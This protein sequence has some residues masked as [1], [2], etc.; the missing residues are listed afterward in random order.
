MCVKKNSETHHKIDPKVQRVRRV[1][2]WTSR[3]PL[4]AECHPS[5]QKFFN[6]VVQFTKALAYTPAIKLR[7]AKYDNPVM[8]C[9]IVTDKL[10]QDVATKRASAEDG[11]QLE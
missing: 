8:P 4:R 10:L 9:R 5:V 2:V 6:T 7:C 3:E 1:Q 11:Q